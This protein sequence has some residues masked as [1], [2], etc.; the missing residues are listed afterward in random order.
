M[1]PVVDIVIDVVV[2]SPEGRSTIARRQI[3]D[4]VAIVVRSVTPEEAW[5]V[6]GEVGPLARRDT[7]YIVVVIPTEATVGVAVVTAIVAIVLGRSYIV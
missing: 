2:D 3:T 7:T 4:S 6:V 5:T 1:E